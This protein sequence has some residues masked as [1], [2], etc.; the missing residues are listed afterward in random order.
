VVVVVDTELSMRRG[1]SHV[2]H[3]VIHSVNVQCIRVVTTSHSRVVVVAVLCF[4]NF[5]YA[6]RPRDDLLMSCLFTQ[7]LMSKLADHRHFPTSWNL[8]PRLNFK[9]SLIHLT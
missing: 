7:H 1:E 2:Y 3:T 5:I 9:N 8:E 6:T 4:I